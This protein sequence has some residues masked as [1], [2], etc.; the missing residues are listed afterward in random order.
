V[1]HARLDLATGKLTTP[2]LAAE[3]ASPGFVALHPNQHVLYATCQIKR[4][5]SVASFAIETQDGQS[6]LK[7]LNSVEIGDGGAAHLTV[8]RLGK[9]LLTAQY[10]GGSVAL[11][12]L[13]DQGKV[14]DRAVLVKHKGGSRIVGNR[15]DSPH[16]HWVGTDANNRFA[17]VPDLGLDQVVIYR[18]DADRLSLSTH[19]LGATPPGGG[20]RHFKFHPDGRFAYVLNELALSVTVF[21]YD[22]SRG[23]LARVQTI[24]T[25]TESQKAGEEFNAASEIRVHPSGKF[26]YAANRGHDSISVFSIHPD[27]GKLDLIEV[28]PIRGSWPRNFNVDPSGRWLIAAGRDSNTLSLFS[29]DQQTGTL[30]YQRHSVFC[31]TPICVTFGVT[32]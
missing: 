32:K 16:A 18:L 8:G 4:R 11:F 27:T 24:P 6:T 22:S 12:P 3:L 2:T 21:A 15:Q 28:E 9:C 10:G 23:Q 19:G 17:F 7:P 5:G 29:I 1:Y 31:P 26:L 13:D 25:L 30:Q 20:P 14:G